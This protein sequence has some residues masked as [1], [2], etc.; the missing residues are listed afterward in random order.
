MD[1]IKCELF[2]AAVD[3]GS[4]T[5]AGE[6]FGY[7]Q[8]GVTR[9]INS[10]E[11]ELGFPLFIRSKKGVV[12]TEN[13]K[14]MLPALRDLVR[15]NQLAEQ[16][17]A[18]IKGIA[19]GTLTIGCYYSISVTFMPAILKKFEKLYPRIKINLLKGGN[20]EMVQWL[21]E[22]SVDCCFCADLLKQVWCDWL[23]LF[24]DEMVVLLP[25]DHP[26]AN[27]SGFPLRE[28]ERESIIMTF[29]GHDTDQDRLLA[30]AGLAPNVCFS[31]QDCYSTYK[32]VEAGLGISFEQRMTSRDWHGAVRE[33][34]FDPPQYISLGIAVPS[35]RDAS[36][37]AKKFIACA[38]DILQESGVIRP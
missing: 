16:M 4:L 27:Q 38:T 9:I 23:P 3:R 25:E 20:H 26:R 2:L 31:T 18:D 7:T 34:S 36:P 1:T 14:A 22:A 6:A 28:L 5:A 35:M 12:L 11:K 17:S 8:S 30:G 15:A 19:A 21:R 29:P 10:L 32:M 24:Q 37:A 33:V 13:G